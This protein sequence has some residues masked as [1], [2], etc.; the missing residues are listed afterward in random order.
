LKSG[1]ER[2]AYDLRRR[3]IAGLGVVGSDARQL[4]SGDPDLLVAGDLNTMGCT[5]CASRVSAA[6]EAALLA[7]ELAPLGLRLVASTTTC[8]EYF[9][10][11]GA[12][13]DHFLVASAVAELPG[14]R[15]ASVSGFCADR[16][17]GALPDRAMPRA[18]RELSDHCPVVVELD[19]RDLD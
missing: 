13:L 7:E 9:Q 2:R 15:R 17:C 3:S 6:D 8:T 11:R 5:H 10:G 16:R 18:Y 4:T 12:L 14:S 1:R 19:D